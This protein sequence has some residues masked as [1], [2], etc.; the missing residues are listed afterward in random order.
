[1]ERPIFQPAGT[2]VEELD[3]PALVVDLDLMERNIQ[4]Y[5]GYFTGTSVT[6]RPVVTSHL[7]PQVARRQLA[8]PASRG[9]AATTLGEAEVFAAAGFDDILV[10]NQVVTGSKI[11]RLCA[12][13]SQASVSVAV[14]S[15]S[16]VD[17]LSQAA[18]ATGVNLDV[19]VEIEAGMGRCGVSPDAEAVALARAVNDAKALNFRGIMATVPGPSGDDPESH[20]R[21]TRERLHVAVDAKDLLESAGLSVPEVSVGGAHCHTAIG[22]L[23]GITEV[24]AGRYP[25]MDVR[26]QSHLPEL[27]LAAMILATVISRPVAGIAVLDAGHKATGPDHG[28]PVL[29][30]IEGGLAARF[31][32]EHGVVEL[33]NGA[34]EALPQGQKARLAPWELAATVNQ[35]DYI[36]AV[37]NGRLEGYWPL[38]A[39]GRFA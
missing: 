1:M 32:A 11:R 20:A 17:Q 4:T 9:I 34:E 21:Q 6:V 33:G 8:A 39:R 30:G 3:T 18:A 31:S 13:A 7:S 23:S 2:P 25:L 24:R 38:S 14:D 36:R 37:R 29:Q 26:L 28:R 12:L 16:N 22:D 15:A 27:S 5:H 19:L 35:Y 10:A